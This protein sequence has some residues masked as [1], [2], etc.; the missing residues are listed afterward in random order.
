MFADDQEWVAD[1]VG[2]LLRTSSWCVPTPARARAVLIAA[3]R[4][5]LLGPW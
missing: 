5:G 1:E 4:P 2:A 3:A